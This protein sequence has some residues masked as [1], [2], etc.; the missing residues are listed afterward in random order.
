M[1]GF[2]IVLFIIFVI[3]TIRRIRLLKIRRNKIKQ[4]YREELNAVLVS[5]NLMEMSD[6]DYKE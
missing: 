4:Q 5:L 1:I 3:L 2:S 6:E